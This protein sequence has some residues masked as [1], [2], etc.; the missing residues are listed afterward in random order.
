GQLAPPLP[1]PG[2]AVVAAF[3]AGGDHSLDRELARHPIDAGQA[4]SLFAE[5]LPVLPLFHRALRIHHRADLRGVGSD[6][7]GRLQLADMYLH[8]KVGP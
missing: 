3:T 2:L 6:R 4:Q 8:G 1:S 7:V 5:R